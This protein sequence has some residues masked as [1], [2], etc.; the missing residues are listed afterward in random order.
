MRG[1]GTVYCELEIFDPR[2]RIGQALPLR[3]AYRDSFRV[4]CVSDGPWVDVTGAEQALI[5]WGADIS[6]PATLRYAV[7]DASGREQHPQAMRIPP[8][9]RPA[10]HLR[11]L[12]PGAVCEYTICF[13]DPGGYP[14]SVC[15]GPYSF[16]MPAPQEAFL[17]AVMGDSRGTYGSGERN[18]G[19]VNLATLRLLLKDAHARG[20]RFVLFSGDHAT[21][22]TTSPR[23]L[24]LQLL[25]WKRA[26]DFV[27]HRLCFYETM[28][29]HERSTVRVRPPGGRR[30][31]IDRPGEDSAEAIYASLFSNPQNAP[32]PDVPGA[33]P[34][35]G[36]VYHFIWGR[37]LFVVLNNDY[38]Y[39]SHPEDLGANLQGYVTDG[40]MDWLRE[41]L[42]SAARDPAIDHVFVMLHEPPFPCG[43]HAG[44]SM[45]YDGG[46]PERNLDLEGN[47]IDRRYVIER[48]DEFW[49]ACTACGKVRA[50]LAGHE[51]NYSRLLVNAETPVYS[52]GSC[53]PEF[54]QP[55]WQCVSGGAGAPHYARDRD[56]PWAAQVAAFSAESN[57]LLLGVAGG[58]VAL[59]AIS[60]ALLEIE[61]RL[62]V[63]DYAICDEPITQAAWRQRY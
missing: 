48:R 18:S 8:S 19:G 17:F 42:S 55:I 50:V 9:R 3:F 29:N 10:V 7:S 32:P 33:P 20:A 24:R 35:T 49:Q 46:D 41:R 27:S 62:L 43:G 23:D 60:D 47:G 22:A 31:D 52:D 44:D 38:W 61:G 28:G 15:Y 5:S 13:E 45:W 1:G 4:P 53:A 14:E 39:C 12:P 26:V 37:S 34:Y 40:Q 51:H 25:T 11:D 54:A 36:T 58:D 2:R 63:R 21:G 56:V 30:V 59:F 57:Y 16:R 6:A